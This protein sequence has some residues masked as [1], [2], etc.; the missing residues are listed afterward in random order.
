MVGTDAVAVIGEEFSGDP[1]EYDGV[2]ELQDAVLK[3]F[4]VSGG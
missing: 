4:F 3:F 2:L 1:L